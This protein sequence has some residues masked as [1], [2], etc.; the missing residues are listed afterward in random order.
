MA[1]PAIEVERRCKRIL[2][3]YYGARFK[4]LI[5]YGSV[6]R[7]QADASSDIDL[8]VLLSQPFDYVDELRQII[9]ILYPVQLQSEQ[10]I[11]AKPAPVDEFEQGRLQLYRSAKREGLAI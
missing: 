1:V 8:L 3:S 2:E 9:E 11:S 5:L 10:L 6:A 4:S 7:N